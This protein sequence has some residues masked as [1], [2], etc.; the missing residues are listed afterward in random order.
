MHNKDPIDFV[1]RK[2]NPYERLYSI[3]DKETL[4]IMHALVMFRK[5]L[6]WSNFVIKTNHNSLRHFLSHKYFNDRQ[7]KWA[8]K[9][10]DFYFD[11]EYKKGKINVVVDALSRKPVLCNA[12]IA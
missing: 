2:F 1:S 3:Y 7:K 8:S 10:Q 11:I 6:V 9:V 5:Y 12:E 4:D